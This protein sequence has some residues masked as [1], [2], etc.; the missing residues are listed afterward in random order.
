VLATLSPV[1]TVALARAIVR[2]P[3]TQYQGVGI[4]VALTGAVFLTGAA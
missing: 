3:V 2:E 4:G 1:M